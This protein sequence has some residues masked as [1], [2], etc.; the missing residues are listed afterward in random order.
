MAIVY[1]RNDGD[2]TELP[3]QKVALSKAFL[4]TQDLH[5]DYDEIVGK[6]GDLESFCQFIIRNGYLNGS[7]N[8]ADLFV[9]T[10]QIHTLHGQNVRFRESESF[11]DFFSKTVGLTVDQ[12]MALCFSLAINY[13]QDKNVLI[14]QTTVI[15]PTTYYENLVIDPRLTESIVENLVIDF[16][17]A[18]EKIS[19]EITDS[20]CSNTPIGYN[21]GIFRKT[22]FIRLGNGKL[23]C[24][25]L[26]CL[27]EKT[28]QNIIWLPKSKV[29]GL[30]KEQMDKLVIELTSYRGKLFEEH[31]KKLCVEMVNKN[32]KTVFHYIPPEATKTHEEV[33]DSLLVQGDTLVILEAKSRQFNE[34]FKY[35]GEWSADKQFIDELTKKA[36]EQ[37]ETAAR[38]IRG[39]EIGGLSI[40]PEAIKRIYPV[41]VAYEPIPMHGKMQRYIRQQVNESGCLTD[42]IFAPLEIIYVGDLENVMDGV[43]SYTLIDVLE[44]KDSSDPH[45][46][47]TNFNNFYS[48]FVTSKG[49]L[50]NGWGKENF[51]TFWKK[52]FTPNFIFKSSPTS[53]D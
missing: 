49:V 29:T 42:S 5:N 41:I 13:F 7:L 53:K 43:E 22:P 51:S 11:S 24:A 45:A 23:V 36:V 35:T 4:A 32:T 38:K 48:H 50:S 20:E 37:I 8:A 40:K 21:L 47:E 28:T 33:G 52:V 10:H 34:S 14:T 16:S 26:S 31:V 27:L 17:E 6:N 18:K 9:R 1:G 25:N 2:E 15:N 39:G 46:S 3:M 19:E 30:T 12:A 44:A